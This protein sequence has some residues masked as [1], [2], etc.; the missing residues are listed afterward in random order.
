MCYYQVVW[1]LI[2]NGFHVTLLSMY[3]WMQVT[4]MDEIYHLEELNLYNK[5]IT[6]Q[7][8]SRTLWNVGNIFEEWAGP[9]EIYRGTL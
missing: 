7:M 4:R 8:N 5:I 9:T 1:V 6:N 2:L 3:V